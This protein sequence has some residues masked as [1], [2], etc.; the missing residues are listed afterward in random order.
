MAYNR[1]LSGSTDRDCDTA[2]VQNTTTTTTTTTTAIPSTSTTT[3][4]NNPDRNDPQSSR[5]ARRKKWPGTVTDVHS[6]YLLIPD[7][8][9]SERLFASKYCDQSLEDF[10]HV[11][12][13]I[14]YFHCF[15]S[16][17]K[18]IITR[19]PIEYTTLACDKYVFTIDLLT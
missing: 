12:G 8:L 3:Q 4:T 10:D 9:Y 5:M 2:D 18:S 11:T 6:D 14:F 7:G 1:K 16:T 17:P 15:L 13:T 19:L